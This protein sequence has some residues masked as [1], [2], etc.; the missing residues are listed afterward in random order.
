MWLTKIRR[1][2]PS[3]KFIS[4]PPEPK[5]TAGR[6][7][8]QRRKNRKVD[9]QHRSATRRSGS[10]PG[11]TGRGDLFS[12]RGALAFTECRVS[13]SATGNGCGRRT[14]LGTAAAPRG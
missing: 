6:S 13:A 1:L 4:K 14:H 11:Q 5:P 2:S 3:S 7:R 9:K 8:N 10:G 12:K